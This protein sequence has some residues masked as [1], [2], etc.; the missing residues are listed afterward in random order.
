MG[1]CGLIDNAG[2]SKIIPEVILSLKVQSLGAEND[3]QI[4]KGFN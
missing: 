1:F 3:K 4:Q 2:K